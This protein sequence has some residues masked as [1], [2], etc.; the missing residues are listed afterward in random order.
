MIFGW[1]PY[2]ISQKLSCSLFY[3]RCQ[4]WRNENDSY[5]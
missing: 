5:L 4:R 1:G 3:N 2:K